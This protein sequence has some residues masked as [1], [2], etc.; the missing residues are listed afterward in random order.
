M[1]LTLP[2]L[3]I[4]LALAAGAAMPVAAADTRSPSAPET[5]RELTSMQFSALMSPGWNLGNALEAIDSKHPYV[6]GSTVFQET[7]WGNPPATR[8]LFDA[9]KAAGFRS[10]R[11]PVS[12]KVYADAHDN[13]SPQWMQ[14]VAQVVDHARAA[15]LIV[16]INLHWDGGWM[17]PTYAAQNMAQTRMRKFWQQIGDHFR[18]YGDSLLFAGTNEVMVDGDYGAPT[19]EYCAVQNSYNQTFV[20]TVRAT[21]GNN[22]RRHLVVQGFNTNIDY[23]LKCNATLPHDSTAQR[24]MMEVHDYDPFDFAQDE[25]SGVWRWGSAAN[26]AGWANEAYTDGQF[27]KLRKAFIAQGIPVLLGE[28]SAIQRSE[29]DP[30]GVQ[31]KYWDS[32]MTRAAHSR[33]IVPMYWDNGYTTNHQ[34]GLFDRGR[35][36]AVYGDIIDALVKASQ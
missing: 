17:Q 4:A 14:R 8:Q 15:G 34:S 11:I 30:A 33:G 22:A 7:A 27:E 20:D 13:I 29:F 35:A 3:S 36:V 2:A 1:N 12:W 26:P 21:G 5:M 16:M 24:L 9:V 31:R 32:Y 18:N 19:S 10:V 25:K 28:Y 6:W 23:T